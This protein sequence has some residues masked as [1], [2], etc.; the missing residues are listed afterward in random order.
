MARSSKRAEAPI[1]ELGARLKRTFEAWR[2]ERNR[3][4][5]QLVT[6][7]PEGKKHGNA[8]VSYI[9]DG[10]LVPHGTPLPVTHT[11]IWASLQIARTFCQLGFEVDVISH[12]NLSFA[13]KKNYDVFLDVRRNLERL[14]PTLEKSCV[15]IMHVDTAH[16]LFHNAAESARLLALQQRRGVTLR[17]SRY[18]IPNLGIEHAD[19]ATTTGN[20][21]TIAT[22]AYAQKPFYRVPVPVAVSMPW[23]KN[24][25]FA[26]CRNRFL[27]FS[28]GGLVHKG[29]DLALEAFSG[30]P[31]YELIVCCPV[32]REK[33]FARAFQKELYDTPNIKT[34]GWV[35]LSRGGLAEI[36]GGC[37]GIVYTSCSEGGGACCITA[38]HSGLA[39]IV[40]RETSVDLHDFGFRI[41]DASVDEIRNTICE[42][43]SL[44]A[45]ELEERSRK[46]WEYAT[47]THTRESFAREYKRVLTEI[48]SQRMSITASCQKECLRH[49]SIAQENSVE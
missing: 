41:K 4:E 8:L 15:K 19:F 1:R 48:L 2:E 44:S 30:M 20:D 18:E 36:A 17:P 37:A 21:F 12:R 22:F 7:P 32:E 47:T 25:D 43:A 35:D 42:V 28:S 6:L 5:R 38:M 40:T 14:T 3:P 9:I 16:I 10:F 29:L 11:N 39:P 13:P 24:K 49:K 23:P 33:Q 26:A 27:W 31:E 45:G 34:I 46:A